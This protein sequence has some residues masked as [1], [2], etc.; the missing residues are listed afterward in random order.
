MGNAAVVATGVIN[1]DD[2]FSTQYE[3]RRFKEYAQVFCAWCGPQVDELPPGYHDLAD[4]TLRCQFDDVNYET[5]ISRFVAYD[6]E[7]LE[8]Q[9]MEGF[10][11]VRQ[12]FHLKAEESHWN[13]QMGSLFHLVLP[14]GYLPFPDLETIQPQ[15]EYGW[16]IGDRFAIGW[17]CPLNDPC[18]LRFRQAAPEEFVQQARQLRSAIKSMP[19]SAGLDSSVIVRR[20]SLREEPAGILFMSAQPTD[21]LSVEADEEYRRI[22]LRQLQSS[23][24]DRFILRPWP[25][26]RSDDIDQALYAMKPTIVHFCGHGSDTDGL[27]FV[28]N[29]R[30]TQYVEPD[31]L[32]SMFAAFSETIKCI[33]LNACYSQNQAAVIAHSIDYVIGVDRA[34]GD[35]AAI[36]FAVGFYGAIFD[37]RK[38]ED[39][40]ELGCRE[41]NVCLGDTQYPKPALF[42]KGQLYQVPS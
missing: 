4:G 14:P 6:V 8:D 15:P 10:Q 32:A 34:I 35:E 40:Y 16:R 31:A 42:I 37:G 38:Y 7:P 11:Y 24:R 3:I 21:R 30:L 9:G 28:G 13:F 39:A 33:V 5:P 27:C 22:Q 41:V 23:Q 17:L 12:R 36:A 29:D 25:A 26:T 20:E 1:A 2:D 19:R 18:T